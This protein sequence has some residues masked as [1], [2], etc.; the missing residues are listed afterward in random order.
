[1]LTF[2]R[3]QDWLK[4][5][6]KVK[7]LLNFHMDSVVVMLQGR[8]NYDSKLDLFSFFFLILFYF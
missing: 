2:Q 8:A 6:A 7:M 4:M 3:F 5:A 1:M